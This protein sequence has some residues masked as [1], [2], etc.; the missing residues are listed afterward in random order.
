LEAD[1]GQGIYIYCVIASKEPK[2]YGP[3]GIGARG[4]DLYTICSDGL[5]AV[6][7]NSPITRYSVS[8]ENTIAHEKAIEEVMKTHAVLPVRFA[9]I[10]ENEEKVIKILQKEHD[11]FK[12]LLKEFRNK[13]EL[14]LKAIFKESVYKDILEKYN[15]IR[16]L[17]Q[18]IE[19]LPAE[20]TYFQR[21]EIGRQVESAL[22]SERESCREDILTMLR[23]LA[24]DTKINSLYGERMIINAAFLVHKAKEQEFDERVHQLDEKYS[25]RMKFKYVGVIPP[26]NFVNLSIKTS[27]Y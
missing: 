24:E 4:D 2:N 21:M 11:K 18:T 10:A 23:P 19:A 3:L 1:T 6:V 22:N 16:G 25:G 15:D 13:K 26:F 17:K 7:S 12:K 14:G 5:A 27:E 9:T 20:K 8:R